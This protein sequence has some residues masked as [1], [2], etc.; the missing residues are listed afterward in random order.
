MRIIGGE[1]RSRLISMPKRVEIRPTQDKVRE[2][3]FNIIGDV[4]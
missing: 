3:V 2:A 1:Y 4:S